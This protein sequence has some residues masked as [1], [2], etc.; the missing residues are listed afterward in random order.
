MR[1]TLRQHAHLMQMKPRCPKTP[2]TCSVMFLDILLKPNHSG[3]GRGEERGEEEKRGEERG[4]EEKRG[5]GYE[6]KRLAVVPL[7]VPLLP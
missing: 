6:E 4:E 2:C 1:C 7:V 5:G 3:A